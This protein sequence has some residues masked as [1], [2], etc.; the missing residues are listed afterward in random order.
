VT[1]PESSLSVRMRLVH[2]FEY[3]PADV[4]LQQLV[5]SELFAGG[6]TGQ[7]YRDE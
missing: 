2:A 3:Q 5:K 1:W 7:G 6:T 4:S